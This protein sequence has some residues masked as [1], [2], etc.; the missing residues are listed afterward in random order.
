MPDPVSALIYDQA[1]LASAIA[2]GTFGQFLRD[3]HLALEESGWDVFVADATAAHEAGTIDLLAAFT[4]MPAGRLGYAPQLLL[5]KIIP[6]LSIDLPPLV[7]LYETLV[8]RADN[9]VSAYHLLTGIEGWASQEPARPKAM[10]AAVIT[11][12]APPAMLRVALVTGLRSDRTHFLRS[13]LG[14]A[15]TGDSAIKDSAI[16]VLG[17]FDGFTAPELKRVVAVLEA[18]LAS[19]TGAASAGPLRSLLSIAKQASANDEVGVRALATIA[20]RT[21][22]AVRE[23][24]ANELMFATAKVSLKLAS[25]AFELLAATEADEIGTLNLI[26]HIVAQ[27]LGGALS[28]PAHRLLDGLLERRVA[29]MKRFDETA[30]KLLTGDATARAA[31]IARWLTAEKLVMFLAVRDICSGFGKDAPRFDLDL[32]MVDRQAAERIARRCSAL[33]LVFPETI[34]SILASLLLTGPLSAFP[35]IE[36]LLFDPLLINYWTGPRTYLEGR[37]AAAPPPMAAAL[38]RVFARHDAYKAGIEAAK[39]IA[40]L[41]PSQHHRFLVATKKRDEQRAIDK[42]AQK[43]S[44]FAEIM[45]MSLMLYGDAAIYDVHIEPGKTIRTESQM[46]SQM[47]FHELPRVDVIDPFGSW[48]FR[49][50][51]LLDG[52]DE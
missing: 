37:V 25:A 33:L 10:L 34:A 41:A 42:A 30:H 32:S 50:Q 40:E 51:L 48:Y 9:G 11:G 15:A 16:Q 14:M 27:H 20:P 13:A 23:T 47:L 26:D 45:P 31:T 12:T 3:A 7:A 24:I 22:A 29:T 46:Q 52:H 36:R 19:A 8:A 6:H 21:D 35:V 17:G 38:T 44:I 28:V 4:A 5:E 39:N 2:G 18:A 49:E 43:Q 1:A